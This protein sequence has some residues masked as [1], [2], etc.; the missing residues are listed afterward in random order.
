MTRQETNI[1][2]VVFCIS[3]AVL[4]WGILC[5]QDAKRVLDVRTEYR[6]IPITGTVIFEDIGGP[7]KTEDTIAKLREALHD[8]LGPYDGRDP[9]TDGRIDLETN[10]ARIRQA[11]AVLAVVE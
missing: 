8:L 7:M 3:I 1:V 4:T 11:Q 6:R 5:Y 2:L 9:G 10:G